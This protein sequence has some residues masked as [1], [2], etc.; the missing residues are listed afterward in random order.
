MIRGSIGSHTCSIEF[1]KDLKADDGEKLVGQCV[2][3][4]PRGHVRIQLDPECQ[5]IG[6]LDTTLHEATHAAEYVFSFDMEHS[7]VYTIASALC[8]FLVSTGLVDPQEF[9]ARLRA[10]ML[11]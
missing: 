10:L 11:K 9:E 3:E 8:Q 6:M 1:V 4:T 7:Q 2:H 5:G